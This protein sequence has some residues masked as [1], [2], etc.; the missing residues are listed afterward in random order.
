MRANENENAKKKDSQLEKGFLD[1]WVIWWGQE[2]NDWSSIQFGGLLCP[3]R[4]QSI[5][6]G[7][8]LN[9]AGIKLQLMH[10]LLYT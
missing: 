7:N 3:H 4:I 1:S 2:D 8:T 9:I 5:V 10:I 6:G